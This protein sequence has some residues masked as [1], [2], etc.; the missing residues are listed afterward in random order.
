MSW[1]ASFAVI[2][3][4]A[5]VAA[6]FLLSQSSLPRQKIIVKYPDW[7]LLVDGSVRRPLNLSLNEIVAMPKRTI[8]AE[9]YCLPSPEGSGVLVDSGN[10]TG[11]NLGFI[12]EKAGV[13]PEAVKVAF[14]ADDGFTTDLT[15]NSAFSEDI[16]LAY[17]KGG[18]P[19]HR[20]L[21]LVVLGR[22]GYKWI[23]LLNRIELVD[24]DFLGS[25]E[26]IGFPDEAEIP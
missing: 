20:K 2:T 10:W 12:L 3:I 9:L 4:V 1:K 23:Y 14:Y 19:L 17:E 13:L 24:Y 21:R 15:V 7:R 26:R 22:W 11:V 6:S 18:E 5:I 25:Y 8:S 16:I